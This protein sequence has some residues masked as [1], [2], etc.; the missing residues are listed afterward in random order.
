MPPF[1][2]PSSLSRLLKLVWGAGA[3]GIAGAA[4]DNWIAPPARIV[5]TVKAIVQ[6]D[7]ACGN[8][9]RIQSGSVNVIVTKKRKPY[10]HEAD[11]TKLGL[12]PRESDI[13]VVKLGYLAGAL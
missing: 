9:S 12:K 5:G 13:V 1:P 4:I 8:G 10:H 7:F 6:G 2:A 3:D 11:F